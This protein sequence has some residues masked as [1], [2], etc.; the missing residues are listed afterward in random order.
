MKKKTDKTAYESDIIMGELYRDSQTE[1]EGIATGVFFYQYGCER[2]NLEAYDPQRK[3]ITAI[4][5]DAPRLVH[6]ESGKVPEV[7][8]TG[9]PG[10]LTESR[11]DP[12]R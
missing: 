9:G 4:G 10:L 1:F 2:V 11:T 12:T 8:R 6:V 7:K 5:F 3:S